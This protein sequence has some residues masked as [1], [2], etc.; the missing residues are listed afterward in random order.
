MMQHPQKHIIQAFAR[1]H[2]ISSIAA[3]V[4]AH[5]E[6]CQVCQACYHEVLLGEAKALENESSY[7]SR[8]DMERA[9]DSIMFHIDPKTS[10][11][12]DVYEDAVKI[13][14]SGQVIKLPRSMT[15]LKNQEI[16]WKEFGKKNA[17]APVSM[18]PEG[19][20]YL[21]YI[22]PGESFP[23][24]DHSGLEY[25]YVAAGSY[26]DGIS[27]FSTGDF[28]VSGSGCIHSPKATSSDGCLVIAW[29]EGRLNYFDGPLRPLNSLLWWYLHRA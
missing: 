24:H 19:N 27:T 23:G 25:S 10:G 21:I 17:I 18:S 28:S 29:V 14:I 8:M 22:G 6:N 3:M 15:F 5:I 13:E 7:L 2:L 9:F 12:T 26:E 16:S 20:F 1:G 4:S 11:L